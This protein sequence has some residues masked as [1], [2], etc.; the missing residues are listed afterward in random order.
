MRGESGLKRGNKPNLKVQHLQMF[1][2]S[3]I[4]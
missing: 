2:F 4:S 3:M 1:S